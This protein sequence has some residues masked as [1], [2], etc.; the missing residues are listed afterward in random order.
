MVKD[1]L[2]NPVEVYAVVDK[3]GVDGVAIINQKVSIC[4]NWFKDEW[5]LDLDALREEVQ[6]RQLNYNME[7]LRKQISDIQ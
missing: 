7:E 3:D 5:G 6:T 2:G 4:R 1:S